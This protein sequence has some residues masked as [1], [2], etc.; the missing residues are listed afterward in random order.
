LSSTPSLLSHPRVSTGGWGLSDLVLSS[1]DSVVCAD[2][3]L[4]TFLPGFLPFKDRSCFT[5]SVLYP[6]VFFWDPSSL[7]MLGEGFLS[8]QIQSPLDRHTAISPAFSFFCQRKC[9]SKQLFGPHFG[10]LT[11]PPFLGTF[12]GPFYWP[13]A[14]NLLQPGRICILRRSLLAVENPQKFIF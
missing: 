14:C 12:F 1:P 11:P 7:P 4:L 3:L 10:F 6:R 9:P 5:F 8:C 13:P 2:F